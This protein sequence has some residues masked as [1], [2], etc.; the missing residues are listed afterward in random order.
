MALECVM[1]S[2]PPPLLLGDIEIEAALTPRL[3]VEAVRSALLAHH[4][5]E[6]VSPARVAAD[7][8]DGQLVFTVGRLAGR[9]HGFRVYSKPFE[10][11]QLVSLWDS[12][13]GQLSALAHGDLLGARR[14]ATIG[15]VAADVLARPE[16]TTIGLIGC[17]LQAWNAL[18]ALRAV[19]DLEHVSVYGRRRESAQAF[20]SRAHSELGLDISVADDAESAVRD[21]DIVIT[22]TT[23]TTPVIEAQW[24][25]P[26]THLTT[27][28]PK[29]PSRHEIP[30]ELADLATSVVTDSLAQSVGYGE[31]HVLGAVT[32]AELS[33]VVAGAAVGRTSSTDI[34]VFASVGL[35]GTEVAILAALVD[36][37]SGSAASAID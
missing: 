23:S 27:L 37:I 35:A 9:F 22:A 26:G 11:Q 25:A 24:L 1:T 16:A 13:T 17:G 14:T 30:P 32:M 31:P 28:G 19:R 7:V 3:A 33:A 6:L 18:W 10:S 5:G 15:A 21:K 8:G 4:N 29:T 20:A 2:E 34:T 36:E 12:R